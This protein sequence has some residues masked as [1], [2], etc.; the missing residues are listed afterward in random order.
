VHN[1]LAEQKIVGTADMT[2]A[3][4]TAEAR[5]A[6]LDVAKLTIPSC[7]V[8]NEQVTN[9]AQARCFAQYMIIHALE[10]SGGCTT[11]RCPATRPPT[12][13]ARTSKL[14]R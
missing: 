8:A 14:R 13:P 3:G 4:I 5:K 12:A 7:S 1:S 10:A 2:P 9:G 6:K 11:R